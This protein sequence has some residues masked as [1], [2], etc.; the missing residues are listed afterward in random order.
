MFV[1]VMAFICYP[2]FLFWKVNCPQKLDTEP[3]FGGSSVER[4]FF[5][6]WYHADWGVLVSTGRVQAIM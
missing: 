6:Y 3:T 1:W 2:L 5:A 4:G